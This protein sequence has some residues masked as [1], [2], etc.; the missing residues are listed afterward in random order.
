ME[1]NH[2]LDERI[3][4][5]EKG[6]KQ[7][8]RSLQKL[9]E[10][11]KPPAAIINSR[12]VPSKASTIEIVITKPVEVKQ[13]KKID[14]AVGYRRAFES[15]MARKLEM[16]QIMLKK[17]W[18]KDERFRKWNTKKL[19]PEADPQRKPFDYKVLERVYDKR[20]NKA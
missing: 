9:T 15:S 7:W 2:E 11:T 8:F 16:S 12:S 1:N 13:R 3:S 10:V 5:N 14:V 6:S 17:H 4:L 20:N 18:E 19:H